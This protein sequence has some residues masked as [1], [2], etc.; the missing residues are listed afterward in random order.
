M[1]PKRCRDWMRRMT[2][3]RIQPLQLEVARAGAATVLTIWAVPACQFRFNW[4]RV[5]KLMG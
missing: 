4:L 1:E 3:A 5:I 2:V